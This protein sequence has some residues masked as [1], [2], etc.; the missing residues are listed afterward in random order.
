MKGSHR[1]IAWSLLLL[2]AMFGGCDRSVPTPVTVSVAPTQKPTLRAS[3]RSETSDEVTDGSTKPP[4]KEPPATAKPEPAAKTP[5]PR[6]PVP[7]S[8][9]SPPPSSRFDLAT[10][11]IRPGRE[12]ASHVPLKLRTSPQWTD[13]GLE[14]SSSY[15]TQNPFY[16]LRSYHGP[17]VSTDRRLALWWY[18]VPENVKNSN[19]SASTHSNVHPDDYVG[20]SRCAECHQENYD[21]WSDHP[22]R[23]MNAEAQDH[24]VK[25]DF[26]GKASISYL[27]GVGTFY[28]ENGEYRMRLVRGDVR[29]VYHVRQTIGSRFFQYYSG[30]QIQGPNANPFYPLDRVENVLPFGYWIEEKEWVPVVHLSSVEMPDGKMADPY[31]G[32]DTEQAFAPYY[33]CNHCHTTFP[34]G[35]QLIRRAKTQ[36]RHTPVRVHWDA[37]EYLQNER[38]ELLGDDAQANLSDHSEKD[39]GRLFARME[40]MDAR[41]YATSLGI[42]CEGCHLG[43]REHASGNLEKP[44]FLPSSPHLTL[45]QIGREVQP[46]RNHDNLNWVCAR[47][48]AGGRPE[49]AAGMS[50]WNSIEYTDALRGSCYSQLQCVD[51]HHPHA[52]TG[53]TWQKTPEEDDDSCLRC[54]KDQ[55]DTPDAIQ[56]HTHHKIGSP[57]SRCMNCHMPRINEGLQDMVRTHMIFSPTQR[58]MVEQNNPNA[59]NMCHTDQTIDWTLKYLKEWYNASFSERWLRRTYPNRAFPASVGWVT[60]RNSPVRLVGADV[61]ARTN[62]RWAI[63]YMILRLDD[64]YLVVR[65]FTGRFLEKMLD[66]DLADHG[67]RFYMTPKERAPAIR[68]LHE[69]YAHEGEDAADLTRSYLPK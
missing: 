46:G 39:V 50:T 15:R 38:P 4:T 11:D 8:Q 10:L 34:L 29:R 27:G 22:H 36:G 55:F 69:M 23:W 59:C 51:C 65:Q 66:I 47:C 57:G 28:R 3:V 67:Y 31:D 12:W 41:R 9:L 49:Y 48:H 37:S 24:T 58:D 21:L 40:Q 45:E 1:R 33:L 52:A 44:T 30:I 32:P 20:P 26:S 64:P 61:I 62:A 7:T 13:G 56:A 25:G 2:G 43:G 35:D 6:A 14:R 54:H 63:P 60:S 68:K 16:T 42:T 19:V 53:P 5:E 17:T 18:G